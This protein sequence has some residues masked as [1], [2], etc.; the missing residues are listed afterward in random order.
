M[1]P[2]PRRSDGSYPSMQQRESFT[3]R[4]PLETLLARSDEAAHAYLADRLLADEP[5]EPDK[6]PMPGVARTTDDDVAEAG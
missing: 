1:V 4:S 3:P 2:S 6:A 5:V